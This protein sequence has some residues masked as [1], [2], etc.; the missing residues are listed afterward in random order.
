[1]TFIRLRPLFRTPII[2]APIIVPIILPSPPDRL[3]PPSTT[4]AIASSS[5][6]VPALGDADPILLVTIIALTAAVKPE[7]P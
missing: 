7:I 5:K 4:A 1:M 2:K 3:V 6:P